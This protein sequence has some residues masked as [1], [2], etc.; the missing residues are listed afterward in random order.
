VR[1]KDNTDGQMA[2]QTLLAAENIPVKVFK[3]LTNQSG[4]KQV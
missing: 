3:F 4:I 2:G 1:K